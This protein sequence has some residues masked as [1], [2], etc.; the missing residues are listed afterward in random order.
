[1]SLMKNSILEYM[2]NSKVLDG[3]MKGNFLPKVNWMDL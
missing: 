3:F 2:R 1:M